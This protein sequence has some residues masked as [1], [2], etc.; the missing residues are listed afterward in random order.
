MERGGEKYVRG[1]AVGKG[2]GRKRGNGREEMGKDFGEEKKGGGGSVMGL[3]CVCSGICFVLA[4][5]FLF[6]SLFNLS[7]YYCFSS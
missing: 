6:I 7:F 1:S 4:F 5:V 3:A 2:Y